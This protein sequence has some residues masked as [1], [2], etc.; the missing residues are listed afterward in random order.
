MLATRPC[1]NC[2]LPLHGAIRTSRRYCSPLCRQS[3]HYR[4]HPRTDRRTTA[5]A[6]PP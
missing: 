1:A 2:G 4:R 3:A 6:A 5:P